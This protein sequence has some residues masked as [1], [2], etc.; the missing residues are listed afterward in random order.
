MFV[1]STVGGWICDKSTVCGRSYRDS[2]RMCSPRC[3][4]GTSGRRATACRMSVAVA[5][6]YCG[7]L[8]KQAN[9]QVAVSVHAV[10]DTAS[11]PLQWR[12]FVPQEWEHDA[13]RLNVGQYQYGVLQPLVPDQVDRSGAGHHPGGTTHPCETPAGLTGA[14]TQP[15]ADHSEPPPAD[16]QPDR[17][18]DQPCQQPLDQRHVAR[19]G[20]DAGAAPRRPATRRG[21]RPRARSAPPRRGVRARREDRDALGGLR[22]S[23]TGTGR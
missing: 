14:P 15:V 4:G 17:H 12:L 13:E 1:G 7:A 5:P 11:V 22:T 10:S 9:G 2:W 8:G 18:Q 19:T 6:Q 23:P 21:P 20:R 16:Q 3:R